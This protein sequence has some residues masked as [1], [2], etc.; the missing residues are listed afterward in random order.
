[1]SSFAQWKILPLLVA[2]ITSGLLLTGCGRDDD[3][4]IEEPEQ[5]SAEYPT[6]ECDGSDI[7]YRGVC[8]SESLFCSASRPTG[9]CEREG[10]VCLDGACVDAADTCSADNPTGLCP[11][12]L[13]CLN[14]RCS[15][16]APCSPSEPN[17][18]CDDPDE[19]CLDGSCVADDDTCSEENPTG[20]CPGDDF[21]DD[22]VCS[23]PLCSTDHPTGLCPSGQTCDEGTCVDIDPGDECSADNPT[24]TCP[25]GQTCDEGTCVDTDP[26]DECSADN[27][28]GTCP[29]GEECVSGECVDTDDVCSASNPMGECPEGEVCVEGECAGGGL[30]CDCAA[31]EV[32]VDNICRPEAVT[33]SEDN[34][35]GLCDSGEDCF[36]G[37]CISTGATCSASNPAGI[38]PVGQW[39]N[40]GTCQS[41]DGSALCDDGN[42]CTAN[43]F[44]AP[45]NICMS[46]PT[47]ANCTDGNA[48]TS[49]WCEDGQCMSEPVAG[50]VEPPHID[51]WE[52]PT[53]HGTVE[54]T[55]TKASGAS[56]VINGDT[57]VSES[58]DTE[59][60]VTLNLQ[61][62]E[63]VY[64]IYSSD[65]G[66]DS[67]VRQVVIYYDN[68]PP[69]TS[70][71]PDG[72][73]FLNG[74]TVQVSTSEPARVF[75][76]TD[77]TTPDEWSDSF[78]SVRS[79]RV[80]EPTEL[81]FLAR[82][83]AGNWEEEVVTAT[84]DITA[85]GTRWSQGPEL[86]GPLVNTAAAV[87]DD[88]VFVV[89][90][91]SGLNAQAGA[92]VYDLHSDSWSSL[93]S[94]PSGRSQHA[95]VA[96]NGYLYAIGGDDEGT[97][98]N[99][100]TRIDVAGDSPWTNVQGM[101]T[102]RY[103]HQAIVHGGQI[104][105][106][107][108]R[109]GAGTA[110][111]T[112]EV[113][114]PSADNWS[115][116]FAQMP[117]A[118][119]A[120]Q[121]VLYRNRIYLI[122]GEDNDGQPIAEIDVYTPGDD[123][124]S[125]LPDLP[126]AR[127]FVSAGIIQNFTGDKG[128]ENDRLVVAGGRLESGA[129][130]AL[131][132]EYSFEEEIWRTRR[133]MNA[134][135]HSA[136]GIFLDRPDDE[137]FTRRQLWLVGGQTASGPQENVAI[138]DH[139]LRFLRNLT[140]MPEGRFG[141][142]TASLNDRIYLFGGRHEGN[143]TGGWSFDPET[144]TYEPLP[145]LPGVQNDGVAAGV[146]NRI[147]AIGGTNQFGNPVNVVHA[148]DPV[149]QEWEPRASMPSARAEAASVVFGGEIYVIGG[150]NNGAV[151]SVEIYNPATDEWRPGPILP[152][153]RKGAMAAVLGDAIYVFGGVNSSGTSVTSSVRL[154]AGSSSWSTVSGLALNA[155]YGDA[156]AIGEE[157][158]AV[159][160]GRSGGNL[161]NTIY[162]YHLSE[163]LSGFSTVAL[164]DRRGSVYYHGRIYLFGGNE[165]P[166]VGP[167][168]S[169]AV[170]KLDLRGCAPGTS[171][172]L[173]GYCD[174]AEFRVAD[175]SS[176]T[177]G[178]T[179]HCWRGY[180]F[181]AGEDAIVQGL[182]GGATA[183]GHRLALFRSNGNTLAEVLA[184]VN[185]P[186]ARA[187]LVEID[188]VQL[189]AGQTYILAQGRQSSSDSGSF[190]T[191]G[192]SIGTETTEG[193]IAQWNPTN[194][195][196]GL[197][198]GP[199]T[200]TAQQVVGSTGS[201]DSTRLDVGFQ[202]R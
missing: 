141:H 188:P 175:H 56:I 24:G 197:G 89:G 147:Y 39:C 33:C 79:F 148:F 47:V 192:P 6:G 78:V 81:R 155:A 99:L 179:N 128:F 149:S 112:L 178:S 115:N 105:V 25:S 75:Y 124:W 184:E 15:T 130:T 102:T 26:G 51:E 123:S 96:H 20:A 199:C 169:T 34:P 52:T 29:T 95:L 142:M 45:A 2:L 182:I 57:A 69:I 180:R 106:F 131:V 144:E 132:E 31:D 187:E 146:G 135:R 110:L 167:A 200:G 136:A 122:G 91:S 134:A 93:P 158:L 189:E 63:N 84:F 151:Q 129:A 36:E 59:W 22:G 55:G 156:F 150:D 196:G 48:C 23:P 41:V 37:T 74:I 1:M 70:V 194:P 202:Y 117:R 40:A 71:T 185:A 145:P 97:A 58:P 30:V 46:Q 190:Y 82:D 27:P 92:S 139:E 176:G 119:Y 118:R 38:C 160:N 183:P 42:A 171:P 85:D 168:G 7:C 165:N 9:L 80:F 17:G 104:Y 111:T 137:A 83:M 125:Q 109:S 121:A 195:S 193:I 77:G 164:R 181:T 49:N 107:G 198:F 13:Q 67:E 87:Y 172:L 161:A 116:Q 101:P 133:P 5:C 60:S 173:P 64:D 53:R 18:Y 66:Q 54:L 170:E 16:D 186:S 98:L 12:G 113:Y 126:T 62:G 152:S 157:T 35:T 72:G 76:T 10:D 174:R 68:V 100:N 166:S 28:T 154:T 88:Q 3:D 61:P 159:I 153:A 19:V 21:C 73:T 14:D 90:G 127:S 44:D 191:L 11:E 138:Y 86:S 143:Q 162:F 4:P 103:G 140:P 65:G 163:G 177:P 108:G 114:D 201:S 120:F 50:C 94:L 8:R 43:W 32:C